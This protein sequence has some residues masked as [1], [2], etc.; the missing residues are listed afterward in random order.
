M[1]L[2]DAQKVSVAG[3][4]EAGLKLADIQK[5]LAADLGLHLTYMEVRFLVDDLKLMPKDPPP[6]PPV[7]EIP[8]TPAAPAASGQPADEA[9]PLPPADEPGASTPGKFSLTVDKITKPGAL[10]S[11]NVTF[12]DGMT[13]MWYLDQ[14]GRMGVVPKEKGYKPGAAD[15]QQFQLA[16][17]AEM[18]KLGY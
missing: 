14:Y 8:K 16:L 17:E 7:K 15:V 9:G 11:G 2:N 4:I 12:S 5:K 10:V 6:P 3:W 13:A 1:N 18:Q